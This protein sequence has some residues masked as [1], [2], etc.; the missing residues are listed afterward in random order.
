MARLEL[1]LGPEAVSEAL[2]GGRRIVEIY[3]ATGTPAADGELPELARQEGIPVRLVSLA[4]LEREASGAQADGVLAYVKSDGYANLGDLL[5]L[6]RSRGEDPIVF[7]ADSEEDPEALGG[8]LRLAD[9]GNV[10][11][12]IVT[13]RAS[14]IGR[15]VAKAA[16]GALQNVKVARVPNLPEALGRLKDEGLQIVGVDPDGQPLH[17]TDLGGPLALV[18]PPEGHRLSPGVASACQRLVAPPFGRD[19]M[20]LPLSVIAGLVL[21]ER[22]KRKQAAARSV[23]A[24]N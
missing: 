18:L 7:A 1:L 15:S 13:A 20:A 21:Y 19:T 24:T 10:H 12:L 8:L 9:L 2:R 3:I 5:D 6:A 16:K 14:P 17:E 4:Q 23:A 11:G 22:Y